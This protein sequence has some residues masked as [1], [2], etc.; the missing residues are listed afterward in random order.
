MFISVHPPCVFVTSV[1]SSCRSNR[2]L[3]QYTTSRFSDIPSPGSPDTEM[4]KFED[5]VKTLKARKEQDPFVPRRAAPKAPSRLPYTTVSPSSS[6]TSRPSLTVRTTNLS[7]PYPTMRPSPLQHKVT[8]RYTPMSASRTAGNEVKPIILRV[9][10]TPTLATPERNSTSYNTAYSMSTSTFYTPFSHPS[11]LE[12]YTP[13]PV[14][15]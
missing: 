2:R 4:A 13:R 9:T 15:V 1:Y 14:A 8:G 12:V 3:H 10:P 6:Q 7:H 5:F 11:S